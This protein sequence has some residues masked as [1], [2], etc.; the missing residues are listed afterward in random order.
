MPRWLLSFLIIAGF[1][2]LIGLAFL[3][4]SVIVTVNIDDSDVVAGA[5]DHAS[6]PGVADENDDAATPANPE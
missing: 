5:A 2:A 3:P 4:R 6:V 1:L